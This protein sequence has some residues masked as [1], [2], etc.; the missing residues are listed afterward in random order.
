MIHAYDEMYLSDA[1]KVLGR[2]F[3]HAVHGIG[4]DLPA[5]Y[6]LFI[7]TD[8]APRFESGDPFIVSGMSGTELA[9]LIAERAALPNASAGPVLH[10]DKGRE[11]WTGWALAYYQWYSGC[12]FRALDRELPIEAICEMYEKYHEM[13]IRHFTD[14]IFEL[15]RSAAATTRLKEYRERLGYS[16]RELA[17]R[18]EIP[19]RT[20]Q[21]YEQGK[22]RLSRARTD[23]VLRLAAELKVTPASLIEMT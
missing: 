16:Q 5:Y 17:R 3:D 22:K 15:R 2:S 23:Y 20:L 8:I 6:R 9:R 4:C 19:V 12:S 21:Q 1:R 14:R 18:T 11:Y 13:D 10:D 7:S